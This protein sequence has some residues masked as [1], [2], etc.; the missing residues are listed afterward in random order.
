MNPL[1]IA[2]VVLLATLRFSSLSIVTCQ[3][4]DKKAWANSIRK[5]VKRTNASKYP[6][7]IS[8]SWS[9]SS[10]TWKFK[11]LILCLLWAVLCFFVNS[12][13]GMQISS[14]R[15]LVRKYSKKG[16]QRKCFA[17]NW[18]AHKV[19]RKSRQGCE[20]GV[21]T[22]IFFLHRVR[23][24]ICPTFY[25]TGFSSQQLKKVRNLQHCVLTT[26]QRKCI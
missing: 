8:S 6:T 16:T 10:Q 21:N 18:E 20:S 15:W 12:D 7:C 26:K 1:L 22:W 19:E 4:K 2:F 14:F 11:Y 17:K 23:H 24:D 9:K 13:Y 5:G 3:D 25:T